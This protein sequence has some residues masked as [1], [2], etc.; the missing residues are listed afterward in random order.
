MFELLLTFA[1][2]HKKTFVKYMKELE[3]EEKRNHEI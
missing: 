3:M 1:Q 2:I